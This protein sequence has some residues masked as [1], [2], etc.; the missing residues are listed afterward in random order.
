MMSALKGLAHKV[1]NL[2]DIWAVA[3][4]ILLWLAIGITI[5]G[6][7]TAF[8]GLRGTGLW[9]IGFCGVPLGYLLA[10]SRMPGWSSALLHPECLHVA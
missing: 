4:L 3:Q 1:V 10:R 6:L 5:W 7:T 9:W 8:P 2:V